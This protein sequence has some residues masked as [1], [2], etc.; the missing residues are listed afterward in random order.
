[1]INRQKALE[2]LLEMLLKLEPEYANRT[3]RE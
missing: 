3:S 1:M 2:G